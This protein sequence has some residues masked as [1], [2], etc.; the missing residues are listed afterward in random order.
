MAVGQNQWYH[1]GVGATHFSTYFGGDW[2]V[3]W[4]YDLD[5][6]PWPYGLNIL[7]ELFVPIF[8]K[9][10]GA[11]VTDQVK[12]KIEE[13]MDKES[14]DARHRRRFHFEVPQR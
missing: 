2:D 1:F 10:S 3:H 9:G 8:R 14:R 4:G 12:A 13:A 11:K 6:D 7:F 5:F